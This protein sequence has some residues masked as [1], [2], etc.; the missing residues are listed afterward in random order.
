MPAVCRLSNAARGQNWPP[1]QGQLN[2]S[3]RLEGHTAE[4][5]FGDA[6]GLD[7]GVIG[8][9]GGDADGAAVEFAGAVAHE[10]VGGVGDVESDGAFWGL[11]DEAAQLAFDAKDLAELTFGMLDHV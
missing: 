7:D 5:V 6:G 2:N 11:E 4:D 1:H 10:D 9:D 3:L 8:G